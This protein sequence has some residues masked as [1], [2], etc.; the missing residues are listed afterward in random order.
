M[1]VF[2]ALP[3]ELRLAVVFAAGCCLAGLLNWGV[4]R[5]A[6]SPRLIS[7]WS[8]AP[9]GVDRRGW[10]D[11][12]PILGWVRLRR[13]AP[14]HGRGFWIRPLFVELGTGGL[15]AFLYWWEAVERALVPQFSLGPP[16][17]AFAGDLQTAV[18]AQALAHG[19]LACLMIVAS[20]IDVDEKTIPDSVTVPG[21]L[22]GLAIAACYPWSLLPVDAWFAPGFAPEVDFL[23]I[24][25]PQPWPPVLSGAP[26]GLSLLVALGCWLGWCFALLPRR[27][28][29]RRGWIKA[30]GLLAARLRRESFTWA[31]AVMG[32]V[33]SVAIAA[34]WWKLPPAH[35]AGFLSSLVGLAVG[36][37]IIWAVRLIGQLALKREAMGFGDVTL[38][39]MIGTFVGWQPCLFIFFLAPFA[40]LVIGVVQWVFRRENEIP[41][42]P[43]LCLAT[44]AVIIRWA[45]LWQWAWDIF[46]IGWLV[47]MV[48]AGCM[49]MMLILLGAWRMILETFAGQE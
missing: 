28:F 2:L 31:I 42:G 14:W 23:R 11:R 9:H 29:L 6:Y 18:H 30:L 20:L 43:F 47:P 16:P 41:Y 21:T 36:G 39:A 46:A 25:S 17:G 37:G 26:S 1:N 27:M 44:L 45:D 8:A 12:L 5:L 40:G 32:A 7:P 38:M 15:L 35:W 3:L 22:L 24:P 49:L 48:L 19:L 4:Y 13:E 10:S 33:G 34:A